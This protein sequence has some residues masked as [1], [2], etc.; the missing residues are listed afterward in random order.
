MM[1]CVSI[2]DAAPRFLFGFCK[3]A[4][5]RHSGCNLLQCKFIELQLVAICK[6]AAT[7]SGVAQSKSSSNIKERVPRDLKELHKRT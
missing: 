5:I 1:G 2:S 3:V 6:R 7:K 4:T